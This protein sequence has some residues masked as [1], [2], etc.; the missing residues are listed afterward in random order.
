MAAREGASVLGANESDGSAGAGSAACPFVFLSGLREVHRRVFVKSGFR[1]VMLFCILV[2]FG[3]SF[4]LCGRDGCW[5]IVQV[6]LHAR[7]T[8][9][10][11]ARRVVETVDPICLIV[12]GQCET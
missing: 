8:P 2:Y 4:A 3:M 9:V 6:A 1:S 7:A 11:I 10:M 5:R 12:R